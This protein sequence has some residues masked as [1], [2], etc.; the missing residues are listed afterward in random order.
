MSSEENALPA[1]VG[2]DMLVDILDSLYDGVYCVNREHKIIFWNSTAEKL[3]GFPSAAVLGRGCEDNLLRH[4]DAEG[5]CLCD[6]VCPLHKTIED[7]KKREALAY[8]HHK[9][10]HRIPVY[11]RT[12]PLLNESGEIIAGI[13]VF[14]EAPAL[15]ALSVENEQLRS[16]GFIDSLTG[17]PNRRSA[18]QKLAEADFFK[19]AAGRRGFSGH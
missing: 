7:G 16:L 9:D 18:E 11:I 19:V 2:R 1:R 13:E 5:C 12:S 15:Q 8:M 14:S 6:S 3:T 10:G 4:V 17:L